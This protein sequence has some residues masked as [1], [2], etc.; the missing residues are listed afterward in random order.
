M[1]K[2][3]KEYVYWFVKWSRSFGWVVLKFRNEFPNSVVERLE[4][5]KQF[6]A[7]IIRK[8]SHFFE[9]MDKIELLIVEENDSEVYKN[10]DKVRI[11]GRHKFLF[12]VNDVADSV[13][14][15][16]CINIDE[17]SSDC[18]STR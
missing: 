9:D 5:G 2:L 14:Y 1:G 15:L 10:S 16:P 18:V 12:I 17:L 11:Y 6:V 8:S 3:D 13:Q 4:D 7:H